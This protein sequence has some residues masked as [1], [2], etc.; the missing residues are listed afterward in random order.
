MRAIADLVALEARVQSAEA[1]VAELSRRSAHPPLDVVR[2]NARHFPLYR[3]DRKSLALRYR[4]N[5][6]APEQPDSL[7]FDARRSLEGPTLLGGRIE[8]QRGDVMVVAD[9]RPYD[10][11]V[12]TLMVKVF[13]ERASQ[14]GY[15][16]LQALVASTSADGSELWSADDPARLRSVVEAESEDGVLYSTNRIGPAEVAATFE[17]LEQFAPE[18]ASV[19]E[20]CRS[21]HPLQAGAHAHRIGVWALHRSR[22][23]AE[24]ARV[25]AMLDTLFSRYVANAM[26]PV[27]SGCSWPYA[28]D[29]KMPWGTELKAPWYSG[30]A[31]A[32]M[33]GAAACVWRLTGNAL[34]R[35][36]AEKGVAFLRT[37]MESGGALYHS[38]GFSFIAEYCYRSPPVPNYRVLDGEMC[39]LVYLY[40]AAVLLADPVLLSFA[41]DLA[42][43]LG[44]ALDMFCAPDGLPVF[45]MD[46]Q[47]M[48]PGYM[49][50]LWMTLQLLANIFKDRRFVAHARRWR[51]AIPQSD[52]DAGYPV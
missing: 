3:P 45:G 19:E 47:P 12:G 7:W 28:F 41:L 39:S 6:L 2:P 8:L 46:G 35:E 51:A 52:V 29:F 27:G 15:V 14:E 43:G 16:T 10:L 22:T 32:A 17:Y 13:H 42:P 4:Q 48:N 36:I 50:Q 21:I 25:A 9:D 49:W 40:N 5:R 18:K 20:L 37:P 38:D 30:Y 26:Q 34:Y 11:S 23:P 31:N 24:R 1:T 33:V 44:H